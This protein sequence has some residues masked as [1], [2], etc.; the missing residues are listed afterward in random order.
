MLLN[1]GQ[2][3]L[4][5]GIDD[6]TP[7]AT[8]DSAEL[9]TMSY[10]PLGPV[11]IISDDATDVLGNCSLAPSGTGQTTCTATVTPTHVGSGTR[12]LTAKY[13]GDG[14]HSAASAVAALTVTPAPPNAPSVNWINPSD[15][16]YGTPLGGIQLNATFTSIV[17]GTTVVV[18][19][20]PSYTPPAGTVLTAGTQTLVVNFNPTDTVTYLP[21]SKSVTLRVLQATPL[22]NWPTPAD[23]PFSTQLSSLQLNAT[24]AWVVNGIPVGVPGIATYTPPAGTVLSVGSYKLSVAFAPTDAVDYTP[25]AAS[26]MLNVVPRGPRAYV[27][28]AASNSVSIVDTGTNAVVAKVAVGLMPLHIALSPDGLKAYVTNSLSQSVSVI[29]TVQNTLISTVRVGLAPSD[30]V[31]ALNGTYVYVS[32]PG[33]KT[34]SV[35]NTGNN[36][37]S[38]INVG[39]VPSKLAFDPSGSMLYVTNSGTNTV[40]VISVQTNKV[41]ATINVGSSPVDVVIR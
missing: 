34:V 33:S 4:V 21:V 25:A 37:V 15:I 13:V 27:V 30:I 20:V 41:V 23:I 26:V 28:N 8:L 40:S 31:V 9:Y 2:V 14:N 39:F 6:G 10:D 38:T 18:P 11:T 36:T 5:G 32:N 35:I 16:V 19:G 29:D 3:L 17:N 22:V 7:P 12:S 1:T 24:F